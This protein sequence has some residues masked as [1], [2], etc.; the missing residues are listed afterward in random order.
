[1]GLARTCH[2][3]RA[4]TVLGLTLDTGAHPELADITCQLPSTRWDLFDIVDGFHVDNVGHSDF[5]D[6]TGAQKMSPSARVGLLEGSSFSRTEDTGHWHLRRQHTLPA[7]PLT[8]R[9]IRNT[10]AIYT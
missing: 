10:I 7:K 9:D 5:W 8:L 4:D 6:P 1:M 3:K 2:M